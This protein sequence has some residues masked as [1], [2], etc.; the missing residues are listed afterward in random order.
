MILPLHEWLLANPAAAGPVDRRLRLYAV[1]CCRQRWELFDS[2]LFRRAV[3]VAEELAEGRADEKER[4]VLYAAIMDFPTPNGQSHCIENMTLKLLQ[5]RG[6]N[7]VAAAVS[8]LAF[9]TGAGDFEAV[10]QAQA[11]LLRCVVGNP[12]RPVAFDPAL[13]TPSTSELATSIYAD[14]A[15]DRMPAQADALEKAGC[16]LPDLLAHCR[17][18]GPHV[19]GCWV[20][21]LLLGQAGPRAV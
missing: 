6:I 2:D 11:P 14:R 4:A 10:V 18:G 21:D 3:E 1:A 8:D 9:A 17:G 19:R 16:G 13:R 7:C 5:N 20:I 15:F 12:F